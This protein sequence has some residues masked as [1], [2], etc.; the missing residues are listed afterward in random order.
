M[1]SFASIALALVLLSS[2]GYAQS[3]DKE[4]TAPGQFPDL[5]LGYSYGKVFPTNGFVKGDN[6]AQKPMEHFRSFSLKLVWQNTGKSNW[7]QLYNMP[8]YGL[9]FSVTDLFNPDEIGYPLSI[10][11]LLGL[12]ILRLEKLEIFSEMQLGLATNWNHYSPVTNPKNI[13]IGSDLTCHLNIGIKAFYPMGK[14]LDL[15]GGFNFTH[16]SNGGLERPNYGINHFAPIIE[17]KY[18]RLGRPHLDHTK[19]PDR[20]QLKKEIILTGNYSR[21][22]TITD[23]LDRHYYTVGGL[24]GY[25]QWQI[26]EAA[27]S[28]LGV[29]LNLLTGLSVDPQGYPNP[30]GWDNIT[31]GFGYQM[32]LVFDRLSLVGGV[33]S[34]ALHRA[35]KSFQQFYQRVGV[36]LYM[37]NNLSL[38]V[39]VRTVNFTTAEYLEFCLGCRIWSANRNKQKA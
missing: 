11:G 20:T 25:Y 1:K 36:K 39:N 17:L 23:T 19:A 10:Y 6:R 30:V 29:D 5:A 34:Y 37:L 26:S 15:G 21:Y 2:L 3:P 22:Q 9:G 27:K 28:G 4:P 7:K 8:Y 14:Y 35:Y 33:G 18:R 38:G 16:Y 32:E 13:A 31:L 12:P 24:S